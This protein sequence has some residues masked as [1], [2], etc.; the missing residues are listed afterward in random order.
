MPRSRSWAKALNRL[1]TVALQEFAA[2]REARAFR[3]AMAAMACDPAMQSEGAAI[4]REFR[5]AEGDGLQHD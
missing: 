1:V 3:Q 5:A 2:R 4:T